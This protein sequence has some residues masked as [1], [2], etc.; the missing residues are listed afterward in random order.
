M[1]AFVNNGYK[2]ARLFS[3][4]LFL[5]VV[6][7]TDVFAQ[8]QIA[9]VAL[10]LNDSKKTGRVVVRNSTNKPIE[11]SIELL[12]GYP[13]TDEKGDIYLKIPNKVSVNAPSATDWIRVYPRRLT[14][15]AQEQQTIRFA[16]RP[17]SKLTSGEYWAR[18]AISAQP[19]QRSS[20]EIENE[21]TAKINLIRRTILSLNYR[22][23]EVTTG[24]S[25][26]NLSIKKVKG[27]FYLYAKL[28]RKGNAAYLGTCDIRIYNASNQLVNH[29]DKEIAVYNNQQRRFNLDTQNLSPAQYRVELTF[30]TETRGKEN[31]SILAAPPVSKEI[32]FTIQ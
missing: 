10:Y 6:G 1:N 11:L 7:V 32:V 8:V 28:H 27:K 16:A 17:P 15:P 18:P 4:L 5:L 31:K 14:L 13:D 26:K 2:R 24:I 12:F 9:P 3:F 22:H 21:I 19:V 30:E 25:V 29:H 20:D 23:K